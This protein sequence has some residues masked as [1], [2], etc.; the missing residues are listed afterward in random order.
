MIIR[1]LTRIVRALAI[2]IALSV[3]YPAAVIYAA[4][5]MSG[6]DE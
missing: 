5:T 2:V 1:I 3:L 6:E 4:F